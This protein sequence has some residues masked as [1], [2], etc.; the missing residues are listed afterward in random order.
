[1]VVELDADKRVE[2]RGETV[3]WRCQLDADERANRLLCHHERSADVVWDREG[4]FADAGDDLGHACGC[5]RWGCLRQRADRRASLRAE[6]KEL[7]HDVVGILQSGKNLP[8]SPVLAVHDAVNVNK[9]NLLGS[10]RSDVL[11][12]C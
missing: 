7:I 4:L 11:H 3:S 9:P 5:E 10:H 12:R 2:D 8:A 1:M 6:G